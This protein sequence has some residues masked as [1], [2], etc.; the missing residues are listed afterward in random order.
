MRV[1]RAGAPP[2]TG[3]RIGR[4]TPWGRQSAGH[5]G[6]SPKRC[7]GTRW[8]VIAGG[9]RETGDAS[10]SD[11]AEDGR[12]RMLNAAAEATY[13]LTPGKVGVMARVTREFGVRDRFE[14]TTLTVGATSCSNAAGVRLSSPKGAGRVDAPGRGLAGVEGS[15][16]FP[17]NGGREEPAG[18][19]R[20]WFQPV[21]GTVQGARRL[22]GRGPRRSAR[23]IG[24][25]RTT[26][27]AS[28]AGSARV[29]P[30]PSGS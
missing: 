25:G 5:D 30:S 29:A 19:G 20:G 24:P 23:P 27:A 17:G 4:R 6:G 3:F 18:S 1:A 22:G 14:G 8:G 9:I 12:D 21:A 11:A 10:G 15:S 13:R 2:S 16:P 7:G 26:R 28:G